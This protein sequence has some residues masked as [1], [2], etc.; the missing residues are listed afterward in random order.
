LPAYAQSTAVG[1]AGNWLLAAICW[2]LLLAA[3]LLG[4]LIMPLTLLHWPGWL[5]KK[6]GGIFKISLSQ[7]KPQHGSSYACGAARKKSK[8]NRLCDA[9]LRAINAMK[10]D[11]YNG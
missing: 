10:N 6:C 3:E 5:D 7:S 9:T 2:A 4:G 11:D 1:C 8:N